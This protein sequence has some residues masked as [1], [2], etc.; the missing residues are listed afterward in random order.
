MTQA[1]YTGGLSPET[2]GGGG[3]SAVLIEKS[4][5]Q[6]GTYNAGFDDADGYSQVTVNVEDVDGLT[7]KVVNNVYTV[8]NNFEFKLPQDA[9]NLGPYALEEAYYR[10]NTPYAPIKSADLSS[11]TSI[12]NQYAMNRCFMQTSI[13]TVNL[14]NLQ[15]V[16]GRYALNQACYYCSSLTS[17]NLNSLTTVSGEKAFYQAFQSTG[18]TSI[19]LHSLKTVSGASACSSMFAACTGLT[20]VDIS[21]LESIT[22]TSGCE[23]MFAG[24]T[25]LTSITF[26]SLKTV[27]GSNAMYRF[28][29]DIGTSLKHV[30]FPA[31][32]SA[33]FGSTTNQFNA[34]LEGVNGCTVHMPSNVQTAFGTRSFAGTN[35]T[36][37][38]DLEPTE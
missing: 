19:D 22:G 30:Y 24:C 23:Y 13:Q 12:S 34:M 9:K 29:R 16:S 10:G 5:T 35:T 1:F 14:S 28:F 18:L 2:S 37:L 6:N 11:L 31:F 7:R 8:P 27:T 32:T 17:L 4:I 21:G 25:R 15:T 36:V 26:N 3:S 38:F 20:S 33:T